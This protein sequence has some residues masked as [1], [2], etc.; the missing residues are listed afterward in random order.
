[1][2]KLTKAQTQK[3]TNASSK[4]RAASS[5]ASRAITAPKAPP[6]APAIYVQRLAR[7]IDVAQ[8]LDADHLLV[9]SPVDVAYLTGFLG[10]DS[11]AL[12]PLGSDA[13]SSQTKGG[14]ASR[15]T[16]ISDFRFGEELEPQRKF[17]NVE[18]R[19]GPMS[20]GL[21][22]VL[23]ACKARRIVVQNESLTLSQRDMILKAAQAANSGAK[24]VESTGLVAGLRIIKDASEVALIRAAV[25]IQEA[26]LEATLATIT[27]KSIAQ[28]LRE[29]DIAATLEWEMKRRGSSAPAFESIVAAGATGSLPH[30]RPGTRKLRAKD[31]LLIDWGATFMGYRSDMTRTFGIGGG[32][33]A[34]KRGTNV[35]RDIYR[36]TLEAHHRAVAM[37]G[38]GASTRE[39]DA[40]ARDHITQA[41]Y[42]ERFGHSL[43]HGI[44]LNVHEGPS[45][46]HIAEPTTLRPGMIVTIE[47]GIYL[48]GVGGVRLENDY[49]ITESGAE[50]LC[51]L[52][53]GLDWASR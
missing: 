9:T 18:M 23:G 41:G 19:N 12:V 40:A 53:M 1:M 49:L 2:A 31:T 38:P 6:F 29:C 35:M 16:I 33:D 14:S 17:C 44:G 39:V 7:L 47:P 24:L 21:E 20:K 51:K 3:R 36:I 4:T 11:Y 42:G 37:L 43:G 45:L 25:R 27:P 48:P 13:R 28:G 8:K 15:A 32:L 34:P 22:R 30:Y 26:A 52:E 50:N 10:G 46:S 5:N